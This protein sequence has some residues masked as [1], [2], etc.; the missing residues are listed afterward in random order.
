[1]KRKQIKQQLLSA[2]TFSVERYDNSTIAVTVNSD[3]GRLCVF[4]VRHQENKFR[5]ESNYL[6]LA[7]EALEYVLKCIS[8]DIKA[9]LKY[10]SAFIEH[11]KAYDYECAAD[12]NNIVRVLLNYIDTTTTESEE[13][14][15]NGDCE[16]CSCGEDYV[17][18]EDS[19]PIIVMTLTRGKPKALTLA[20]E[21]QIYIEHKEGAK[22]AD[23][24]ERFNVS[25]S[26]IART[27]KRVEDRS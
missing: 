1:M 13:A 17:T 7:N 12:R 26:T 5:S 3:S 20:N 14:S 6:F 22:V 25:R 16:S 8:Q 21:N 23:L 24:A 2:L 10:G 15:C 18:Q 9:F 4:S 19:G 27:I 11:S